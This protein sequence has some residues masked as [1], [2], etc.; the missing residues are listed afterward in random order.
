MKIF[1]ALIV[2]T[3]L[4]PAVS[5]AAPATDNPTTAINEP[6][7]HIYVV[8]G[9][10]T[11]TQ[12]K[13][14]AHRVINNEI[15]V[16]NTLVN[17][18]DKSAALLRFQ[19]GQIV[20]MQAN[21]TFHVREY[22]YDAKK[23]NNSNI[24]FSVFRGGMR[25]I[26]GLIGQHRKQSFKVL[27]PT[28]TIGIRGT[29]FMV[30]MAGKSMYSKVLTG[31][32]EMLNTGGM[33][34]VSAGQTAALSSADT[35]AS[36]VSASAIPAGT[37]GELLAIP[38]QPS[39][40][41]APEPAPEPV[42]ELPPVVPAVVPTEPAAAV[43]P[44][45]DVLSGAAGADASTSAAVDI[46]AAPIAV[47]E[48]VMTGSDSGSSPVAPRPV[49]PK[50]VTPEATPKI[51]A[52]PVK[53]ANE[54]PMSKNS[55][56]DLGVTGK[57]GTLGYGAELNLG[58]T[59]SLGARIGVNA[60]NYKYN[61]NVSSV[62]YDLKLQLQTISALADWYPLQGSFRASAGV[63]YDGNKANLT[64][65]PTGVT[66]T[67]NGNPYTTTDIGSLQ[68]T[69][70]FSKLAPYFGIGWGNPTAKNKGWGVVTD[71][72]VIFQGSPKIDLT[73]TC[74]ATCP[75]TLQSDAEAERVKMESDLSKFK[76]WP[77]AS[78]GISYQW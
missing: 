69:M 44:S 35:P 23:I 40:I 52:E 56:S 10:V 31:K 75:T 55:R 67:I 74:T 58:L 76:W 17:T 70:S 61:A 32:I 12:G 25:F 4:F 7:S 28:A 2:L 37:F 71:L 49:A 46:A 29:E 20:T 24:V 50:T 42:P 41:P 34:V 36:L 19:D 33:R 66:Y 38:I 73:V 3:A 60:F 72:G 1:T 30:V 26:T 48:G 59:D 57:I 68:A 21:S 18:G 43:E 45:P 53:A 15:I 16:S 78:I 77:V 6:G 11:V 9:E 47:A 63:L 62:N 27:T 51:S 54:Q 14:P 5:F 64:G 13:H 8:S 39:A 22:R 65:N